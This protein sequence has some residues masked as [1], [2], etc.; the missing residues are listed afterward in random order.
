MQLLPPLPAWDSIHVLVVHFPIALLMVAPV[1][2]VL[3][4]A[5]PRVG[6]GFSLSAMVVMALGLGG[7]LL[8]IESG[9]DAE[10]V[11][12]ATFI[13]TRPIHHAIHEHEEMAEK[14]R[15]AFILLSLA[16]LAILAGPRLV[17]KPL[18]RRVD[19]SLQIAFLLCYLI[20][21]SLLAHTA[22]LGGQLVHHYG[23]HATLGDPAHGDQEAQS[24]DAEPSG[25]DDHN[26]DD[27]D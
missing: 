10:D 24:R 14:A 13:V 6:F 27:D 15:T 8:A 21:I 2:I 25:G 20:G 12:E 11:A 19:R 23:V 7:L 9:E 3:G 4:L 26:D 22:H 16:Y 5:I 1:L 18:A 17:K